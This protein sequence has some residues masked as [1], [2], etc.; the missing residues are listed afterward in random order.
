MKKLALLL[1]PAL[2]ATGCATDGQSSSSSSNSRATTGAVLGAIAGAVAGH[3]MDKKRGALVGAVVGAAA[4][5]AIGQQMDKQQQEFE[6]Q[7]AAEQRANQIEIERV[8]ED[9][10]KLTLNNEV[11]F[12]FNSA[13]LEPGFKPSLNKLA[14]VLMNNPNTA[15][16]IVGHTDDK[17]SDSY[18][19]QLSLRRAESVVAYLRSRGVASSRLSAEGR[20]ESEP[21]A[22]N[23]TADGR[24]MNRRVE[25][26]STA[27]R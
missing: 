9:T 20:G 15:I 24:A 18:N 17:G 16:T 8:R 13:D 1:I 7:L 19:M 6:E 3:Q 4:G 11:S 21:R 23:A 12:K 2:V 27:L 25:I 14:E 22:S 5:G 26:F 10:L